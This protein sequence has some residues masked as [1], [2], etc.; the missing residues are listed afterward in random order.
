VRGELLL[1]IE[2]TVFLDGPYAFHVQLR[3]TPS[4]QRGDAPPDINERALLH[5]PRGQRVLLLLRTVGERATQL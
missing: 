1:R 3:N 4:L 5:E 2:P